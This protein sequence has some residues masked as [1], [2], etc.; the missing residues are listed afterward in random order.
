MAR[1]STKSSLARTADLNI[2]GSEHSYAY[3]EE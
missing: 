2:A 1:E 3:S